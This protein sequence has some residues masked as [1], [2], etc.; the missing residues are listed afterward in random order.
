MEYKTTV[1]EIGRYRID[2]EMDGKHV[3]QLEA[4]PMIGLVT[5]NVEEAHRN[6]G[7]GTL[8]LERYI[9]TLRERQHARCVFTT[10]KD[11]QAMMRVCEKLGFTCQP[12]EE[13]SPFFGDT[14][15]TLQL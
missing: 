11:N 12:Q 10:D 3:G 8:L 4:F 13:D 15:V 14:V 6:R 5:L 1:D 2:A 9:T 7:I